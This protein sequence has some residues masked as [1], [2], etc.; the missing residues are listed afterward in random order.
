MDFPCVSGSRNKQDDAEDVAAAFHRENAGHPRT[1]PLEMF[2]GLDDPD[3][4]DSASSDGSLRVSSDEML[5]EGDLVRDA[6]AS[7]EEEDGAVG[8]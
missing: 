6:D 4:G 8:V 7:G 3:E 5:D 2:G 1:D